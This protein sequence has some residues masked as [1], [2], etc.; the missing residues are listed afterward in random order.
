M[1]KRTNNNIVRRVIL[2]E[3]KKAYYNLKKKINFF[4]LYLP[5]DNIKIKKT[6][7]LVR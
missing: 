7:K 4:L 3:Q 1:E 6:I 5:L 2:S